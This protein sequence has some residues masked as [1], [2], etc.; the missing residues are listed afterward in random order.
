MKKY[1]DHSPKAD[2]LR[3]APSSNVLELPVEPAFISHPPRIE[4]QA[5]YRR[6]KEHLAWRNSR[7][8]EAE[9]RLTEKVSVEFV[10]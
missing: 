1:P 2:L 10:L 6:I 3:D 4:P 8:G 9:R 7:P 5:M